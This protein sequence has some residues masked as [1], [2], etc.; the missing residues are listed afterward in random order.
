[1]M[2]CAGRWVTY[3]DIELVFRTGTSLFSSPKQPV[4]LVFVS[5]FIKRSGVFP[6]SSPSIL[7]PSLISVVFLPRLH[8]VAFSNSHVDYFVEYSISPARFSRVSDRFLCRVIVCLIT[9]PPHSPILLC[10]RSLVPVKLL[11]Q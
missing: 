10:I 11:F 1:M 9:R 5:S 2:R 4:I 3:E 6:P 8:A 7:F